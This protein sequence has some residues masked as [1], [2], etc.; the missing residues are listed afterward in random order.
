MAGTVVSGTVVVVVVVDV[1]DE[2]IDSHNER[3]L[4]VRLPG[5]Q[6]VSIEYW[7]KVN[8]SPSDTGTDIEPVELFCCVSKVYAPLMPYC[9]G[10]YHQPS[11][12]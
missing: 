5:W 3:L 11:L 12:V 7:R 6:H 4:I 8:T 10:S 1:V 9:G 2:V